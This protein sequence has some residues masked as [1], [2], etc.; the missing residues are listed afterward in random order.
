VNPLAEVLLMV[1]L[2]AGA[3]LVALGLFS[4]AVLVAAPLGL[5]GWSSG[6]SLWVLFPLLTLVGYSMS[7]AGAK[8]AHVQ[9]FS[10]VVSC[11]LL[12][13]ALVAAVGLVLAATSVVPLSGTTLPLWY[14]LAIAGVLGSIGAGSRGSIS[15][16]S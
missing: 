10:F 15:R 6:A 12:L 4:G 3:L 9:G 11:I 7:V 14:V 5:A 8:T 1:L 2:L 13:L 16:N